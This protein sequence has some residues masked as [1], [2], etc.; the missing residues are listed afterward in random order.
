[1]HEKTIAAFENL[2]T[3]VS[4]TFFRD[5]STVLRQFP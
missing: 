3:K 4:E 5:V 1:M 2:A